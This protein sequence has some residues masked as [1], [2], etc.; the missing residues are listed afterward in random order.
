MPHS[1][2]FLFTHFKEEL[3]VIHLPQHDHRHSSN[4]LLHDSV[5]R[6][7]TADHFTSYCTKPL[8]KGQIFYALVIASSI[9]TT[10]HGNPDIAHCHRK[11]TMCRIQSTLPNREAVFSPP[12]RNFCLGWLA[13]SLASVSPSE[14]TTP[15]SARLW[16][17][18]S[19]S[20]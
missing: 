9:S 15:P 10:Q 4:P 6:L 16:R 2:Y 12:P 5:N 18:S 11:I 3:T 8:R 14:R 17:P 20:W 1:P 19:A 13:P 7:K